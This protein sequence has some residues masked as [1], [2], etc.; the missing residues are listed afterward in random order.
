LPVL[1]RNSVVPLYYQIRQRLLQQIRSGNFKAGELVP[2]EQ[3]IS[4]QLGVSRM[5]ARQALKSLCSL[6][7]TYSQRGKGTF[8]SQNKLEKNF[9]QVLSFSE[10]MKARGLRPGSK[11]LSFKAVAAAEQVADALRLGPNEN[12][13]QLKRLRL[14][15][16]LPM[17]VEC[18]CI[19][20]SLCPDFVERFDPSASLYEALSQQ[21]GIRITAAE[22][23]VEVGRATPEEARLLKIPRASAIFLFTRTSFLESGKAVEYVRSVYRGDRYKFVHSLRQSSR[24]GGRGRN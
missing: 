6:G 8:V 1:D 4:T 10:E 18:T 21:C 24:N 11:V 2:S 15:D 7:V 20:L 13:I 5:T 19:P 14:A 3:E 9:R 22:E 16:S 23:I 12:V 17:A